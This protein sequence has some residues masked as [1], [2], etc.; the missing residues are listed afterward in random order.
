MVC[1]LSGSCKIAPWVVSLVAVNFMANI[2]SPIIHT[3]SEAF[4]NVVFFKSK[5]NKRA[6]VLELLRDS[7][8]S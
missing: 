2:L 5:D 7:Y 6:N 1:T 3:G 4:K 8:V